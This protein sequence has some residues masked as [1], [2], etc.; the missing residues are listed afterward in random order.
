MTCEAL[1][2][3]PN[4]A[5]VASGDLRKQLALLHG[6]AWGWAVSCCRGDR[7][8]AHDV[9][10]D[11]Y[12]RILDGGATFSGYSSFKTWVFGV[13]RVTAMAT[14]RRRLLLDMFF[15]PMGPRAQNVAAERVSSTGSGRLTKAIA[16]LPRRQREV[17]SLVFAHDLTVEEAAA[18]MNVS[19]GSARQHHARAKNKLRAVLLVNAEPDHG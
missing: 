3:E 14:R 15:E 4:D 2:P 8:A 17:V 11:A 1:L 7:Q 5:V 16:D 13:V 9:L 18:V 12:L 10:H 19:V 6:D